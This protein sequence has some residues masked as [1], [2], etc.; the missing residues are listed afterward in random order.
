MPN[1]VFV[2]TI[3]DGTVDPKKELPSEFA[4]SLWT[5]RQNFL[6]LH[7]RKSKLTVPLEGL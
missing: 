6:A 4:L 3:D 2:R 7:R 1:F 5:P